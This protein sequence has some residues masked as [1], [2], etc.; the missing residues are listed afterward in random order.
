MPILLKYGILRK[1][2]L[3]FLL[4]EIILMQVSIRNEPGLLPDYL[5]EAQ[6]ICGSGKPQ[7]IEV[8]GLLASPASAQLGHVGCFSIRECAVT[9]DF[10]RFCTYQEVGDNLEIHPKQSPHKDCVGQ[11]M[12]RRKVVKG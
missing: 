10:K 2:L 6:I 11:E 12:R 4:L 8:F 7:R 1:Y 9:Q 3:F 5:R